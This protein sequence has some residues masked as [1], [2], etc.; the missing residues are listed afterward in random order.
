MR[1]ILMAA[2]AAMLL[3]GCS[4]Q[5]PQSLTVTGGDIELDRQIAQAV[6]DCQDR[7]GVLAQ[8]TLYPYH[9]QANS[10]KLNEL[11]QR[12][13]SVLAD[14]YRRDPGPLNI[15]RGDT[16]YAFYRSRV[17]TVVAALRGRG[18][19]TAK[20][21]IGDGLAGGEGISSPDADRAI[22]RSHQPV[23]AQG[24]QMPV[25]VVLTPGAQ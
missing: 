18:V 20:V 19:D 13:L 2:C 11:G 23:A 1:H 25:G 24:A 9:F 14:A 10:A 21:T 4:E 3:A 6:P 7:N 16:T 8:H 15:Q 12:D 17:D 22:Q 5:P